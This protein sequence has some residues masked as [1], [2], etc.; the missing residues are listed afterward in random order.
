MNLPLFAT[1]SLLLDRMVGDPRFL[2]HPVVL[3]GRV[4]RFME[5]RMNHWQTEHDRI[6]RIKGMI[7][8]VSIT[9]LAYVT[10]YLICKMAWTFSPLVG[11]FVN[12]WLISTTIAWKG[13]NRAGGEVYDALTAQGLEAGRKAVSMIVGRDA[14]QMSE[15]E[16]VRATV[17]TLAENV[18]DAIVSPVFFAALGG[19]PLA[20]A[21]RAVNTLDSMVGYK[22][23][24]YRAFGFASARLD[25][26]LNYLPAR[27][28]VVLLYGALL[29]KRYTANR[30]WRVMRRDARCHPSPNSGYP[31]SMV[32]GG[33]SI[34]LGGLNYYGGIP[35]QRAFMGDPIR[36]L[37]PE[38]IRETMRIVEGT[39]WILFSL[40]GVIALLVTVLADKF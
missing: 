34:Q 33:L 38:R 10:T 22:N 1:L 6:L 8:A 17:E 35:S 20:F 28:T 12:L 9:G 14:A 27:V 3:M 15:P 26:V 13:L 40:S 31:E 36:P 29:G 5:R 2:I 37:T 4:I 16:V 7:L 19:A 24:R 39:G 11:G 18:V 25:D 30:A 21:Y 23:E 32:A